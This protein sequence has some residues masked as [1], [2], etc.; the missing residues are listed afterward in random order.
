MHHKLSTLK[1]SLYLVPKLTHKIKYKKVSK[2]K[3]NG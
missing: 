2:G 3:T 1:A